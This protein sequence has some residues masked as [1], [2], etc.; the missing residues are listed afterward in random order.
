MPRLSFPARAPLAAAALAAVLAFAPFGALAKTVTDL[1]GRTVEVPDNVERVILG[2]GRLM[3][4]LATLDREDPFA[5]VVG[6]ADDLRTTD[7]VAYEQYREKFPELTGIAIT[8]NPTSGEFSAEKAIAL[9]PDVVFMTERNAQMTAGG[10]LL[11]QFAAAGVPVV[12]V[13]FR[14]NIAGATVPSVKLMGDVLGREVEAAE[15]IAFYE[16]EMAKVRDRLAGVADR[17]TVFI[18]RTAG[19]RD[20]ECCRSFGANNM[21]WLIETAGGK[22]IASGL[23]PGAT[24]TINPEQMVAS[25]PEV[26][27]ASGSDWSKLDPEMKAVLL[28]NGADVAAAKAK[29]RA[30]VESRPVVAGTSAVKNNRVNAIWHQ[31]YTSPYHFAA[32]QAMAR[33]FHPELFAD[34]DPDAN[35]RAFHE[36]FLPIAYKGGYWVSLDD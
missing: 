27:I 24:G 31:F 1:A 29:L 3:Y 30:L 16:G 15:V 26:Y 14:D 36:K 8:G 4:V 21:G 2:E 32:V 11:D 5:R 28:G 12:F 6:W 18:E 35:F 22:N 9:K 10:G 19:L 34:L 13:D 33:W 7:F 20:V 23:I 17:P 25:S